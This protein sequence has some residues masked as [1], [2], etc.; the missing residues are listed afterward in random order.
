MRILPT[1]VKQKVISKLHSAGF[2]NGWDSKIDHIIN[3]LMLDHDASEQL[4]TEMWAFTN[5]YDTI[6]KQ[7]Y[8]DTFKEFYEILN[9]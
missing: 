6:R 2:A 8:A 4:M 9:E 5:S 1:K 7:N 3:F